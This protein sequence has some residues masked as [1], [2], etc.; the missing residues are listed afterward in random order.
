[1]SPGLV[2][3]CM[4][5]FHVRPK[6]HFVSPA[7]SP[8]REFNAEWAVWLIDTGS[9]RVESGSMVDPF[10][11]ELPSEGLP[12][13]DGD[14][15]EP[16]T[17][18]GR[19]RVL[20]SAERARVLTDGYANA[21]AMDRRRMALER[22][23]AEMALNV[24]DPEVAAELRKLWVERRTLDEQLRKL[25]SELKEIGTNPDLGTIPLPPE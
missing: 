4:P 14:S 11:A 23:I 5:C 1:M 8:L 17:S 19:S 18:E 12:G 9:A 22:Q 10:S 20:T 6:A 21:L 13:G 15:L 2:D 16:S 7:A 25:R 24:E 3:V